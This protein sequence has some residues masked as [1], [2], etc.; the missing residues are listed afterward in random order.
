M[1]KGRIVRLNGVLYDTGTKNRSFLQVA[2]DLKILGIKNFYFMLRLNDPTLIN[3][4]PY[5]DKLTE[6][7]ISRILFECR[8]NI[9]YYLREICRIPSQGGVPVHFIANRGNIAQIWCIL[10]GLDSWLCLPRRTC[11]LPIM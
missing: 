4:D 8:T 11:C 5:S 2:N 10:H 9:W 3:V 1:A 6:D 7:Q